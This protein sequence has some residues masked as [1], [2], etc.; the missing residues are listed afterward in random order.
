MSRYYY[1]AVPVLAWILNHYFY[2]GVHY[3]W[4]AKGFAPFDTN[5]KSSNPYQIYGDLYWAWMKR[6]RYDK[7]VGFT[8]GILA[9]IIADK[10]KA[11]L[12]DHITATRL[13]RLCSS[14]N[15][16]A[17]F[18]PIVY[19]VDIEQIP[20]SRQR[21]EHSGLEG[22][23]EVLV[24]DLRETEFDLLFADN[25][26]DEMFVSLVLEEVAGSRRNHA[27]DALSLL[28]ERIR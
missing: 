10:Q 26:E 11:G 16:V 18:Y 5:P 25:L 4:L 22:S 15:N 7:Y 13:I 2:G 17:L 1:G 20:A 21:V 14:A 6:D 28:E 24:E 3:S 9:D 23:G 27:L 12:L 19:R 8:R